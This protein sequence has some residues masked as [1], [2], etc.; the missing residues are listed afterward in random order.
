LRGKIPRAC[1]VESHV[2][3]YTPTKISV[4]MPRACPVEPHV[5]RLATDR[6]TLR[7]K[8]VASEP[9]IVVNTSNAH[10]TPRDKPVVSQNSIRGS[11]CSKSQ[12]LKESNCKGGP[13]WPPVFK[14][15]HLRQKHA[16]SS[17]RAATEGRPYSCTLA[18]QFLPWHRCLSASAGN[19]FNSG[20]DTL[21]QTKDFPGVTERSRWTQTAMRM[22]LFTSC[23]STVVNSRCNKEPLLPTA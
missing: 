18:V 1:P 2:S 6:E 5:K 4:W 12:M 3:R 15:T 19:W 20:R 13:P 14:N 8:P 21:A 16:S 11:P 9:F 10:E 22:C 17:R 23:A 7:G